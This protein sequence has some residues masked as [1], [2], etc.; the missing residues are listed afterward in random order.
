MPPTK[1]IGLKYNNARAESMVG[2][3]MPNHESQTVQNK[4]HMNH[5]TMMETTGVVSEVGT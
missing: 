5:K 3:L 1:E 2:L 4:R